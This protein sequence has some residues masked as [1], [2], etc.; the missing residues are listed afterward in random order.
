[1]P[2]FYLGWF[3]PGKT[4]PS[5]KKV[6][7]AIKAHINYIA[8]PNRRDLLFTYNLEIN[9]WLAIADKEL[10]KRK[11][12][13]T[14]GKLLVTL[15]NILKNKPEE[16]ANFVKKLMDYINVD[17]YGYA[18]HCSQN[19]VSNKENLHVHIVFDPRNRDGK[20]VR[21][22]SKELNQ[23]HRFYLSIYYSYLG[24][25]YQIKLKNVL[26]LPKRM[27]PFHF[28]RYLEGT[29][30][31][32]YYNEILDL[33]RIFHLSLQTT[34]ETI[35]DMLC[36]F[37]K[38]RKIKSQKLVAKITLQ[39]GTPATAPQ[40]A[41]ILAQI[42]APRPVPLT[43]NKKEPEFISPLPVLPSGPPG[44]LYL[45]FEEPDPI[46]VKKSKS[47]L[48]EIKKFI[49]TKERRRTQIV[50]IPPIVPI[51][52]LI[53]FQPNPEQREESEESEPDFFISR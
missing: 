26:K 42:Q 29:L 33:Y 52:P 20:K 34:N 7:N 40:A 37:I 41:T 48:K 23:L 24:P 14:T 12:A 15:P 22:R 53:S 25:K 5:Y 49:S 38:A 50:F 51:V 9:K 47:T 39:P 35:N 17:N 45:D 2:Y 10:S 3:S 46:N 16:I 13:T 19:A 36:P 32:P 4:P 11:N 27:R 18:V 44:I 8:N 31:S 43:S 30:K 6:H 21:I 1:M 28:H